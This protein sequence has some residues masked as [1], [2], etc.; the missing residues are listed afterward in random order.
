MN[1][2]TATQQAQERRDVGIE[3]AE[4]HANAVEE[5]WSEAAYSHL[6]D[7]CKT[8]R[9]SKRRFIVEEVRAYAL[10]RG[11]TCAS[12]RAWGAVIQRAARRGLIVKIG[13][14]P[15]KSSNLSPKCQW[16][17]V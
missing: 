14:A 6:F 2:Q 1:A 4:D 7:F 16:E 5:G 15:A 17:A 13:Y 3:R 8:V 12:E 11:F 9:E 10:E